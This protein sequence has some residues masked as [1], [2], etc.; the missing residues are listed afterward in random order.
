M[1]E[2]PSLSWTP[3]ELCSVTQTLNG[4]INEQI[5]LCTHAPTCRHTGPGSRAEFFIELPQRLD[6]VQ[7]SGEVCFRPLCGAPLPTDGC[8]RI[9]AQKAGKVDAQRL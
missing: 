1:A 7:G 9:H 6:G 5:M 2:V 8:Q 4:K 3:A